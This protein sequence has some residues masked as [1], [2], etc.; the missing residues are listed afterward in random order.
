V[1]KIEV[2]QIWQVIDGDFWSSE[3]S[4]YYSQEFDKRQVRVNFKRGELIE[5]RYPFA[6]HLRTVDNIYIHAHPQDILKHCRYYGTIFE[7]VQQANRK[8]LKDILR[9]KLYKPVWEG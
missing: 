6:W 7:D 3:K 2:G 9:E 4:R 5:I 8:D 1:V